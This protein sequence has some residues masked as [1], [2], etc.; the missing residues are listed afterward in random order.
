MRCGISAIDNAPARWGTT[1]D[2]DG[3]FPMRIPEENRNMVL[4]ATVTLLTAVV[5]G[6]VSIID[7]SPPAASGP[8]SVAE[9][10]AVRTVGVPFAPNVN[11]RER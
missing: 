8:A 4:L 3:F 6:V 1:G 7:P 9:Q 2:A 11:P 10:A 5:A